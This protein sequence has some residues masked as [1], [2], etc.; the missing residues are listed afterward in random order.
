M[1]DIRKE[2]LLQLDAQRVLNSRTPCIRK[3]YEDK[4]QFIIVMDKCDKDLAT[5]LLPAV[6]TSM[7]YLDKEDSCG[8]V[9]RYIFESLDILH[10][11]N[12][13]H[14]DLK[15]DNIMFKNGKAMIIDF[16]ESEYVGGGRMEAHRG[17]NIIYYISPEQVRGENVNPKSDVWMMGATLYKMLTGNYPFGTDIYNWRNYHKKI[18][19]GLSL[20]YLNAKKYSAEC[21]DFIKRCLDV[22]AST[23]LSAAE[24]LHHPWLLK[25][26]PGVVPSPGQSSDPKSEFLSPVTLCTIFTVVFVIS[27]GIWCVYLFLFLKETVPYHTAR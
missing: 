16:G 14:L 13:C 5:D 23:R 6:G 9:L 3:L 2:V 8:R 15:P 27:V 18:E 1:Y 26:A 12:I 10:Q 22:N 21:K 24:A 17:P 25:Y 20:D 7:P 11:R 4:D 19:A